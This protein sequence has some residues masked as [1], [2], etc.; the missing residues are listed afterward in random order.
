MNKKLIVFLVVLY[1]LSA[2]SGIV[3]LLNQPAA[4]TNIPEIRL[5]GKPSSPETIAIIEIYGPVRMTTRTSFRAP[6]PDRIVRKLRLL[7]E[8]SNVKAVIL[9]INSPGG[10]VAAVQEI[11]SEVLNLRNKGKIVVASFGDI[12]ASGGYYI[13]AAADKIVANP[14]TLT[15]SVGVILELFQA[16]ELLKK[17]GVRIETIKSGKHKDIGSFSRE[18]SPEEK[19]ILLSLIN[20]AYDQFVN[21]IVEGR[22]M[23][24]EKVLAIADGRIFTGEQAKNL[25]MVDE[26]G[27]RDDAINLAVKLAGI[28]GTPRIIHDSDP[29]EEFLSLFGA[30]ESVFFENAI[31]QK[32]RFEYMFE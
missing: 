32:V 20:N 25:G 8:R 27:T 14:G 13:A 12:A 21:A 22:K 11:Y 5:S 7:S 6:N 16:P 9:R 17:I 10:T 1:F 29:I 31:E 24:R 23:P 30:S 18:I 28:K 19:Q 26:L 2:V 3:I 4:K 15:G